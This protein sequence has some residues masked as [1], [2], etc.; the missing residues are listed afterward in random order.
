MHGVHIKAT[1]RVHLKSIRVLRV[2]AL[3]RTALTSALTTEI[4]CSLQ[5]AY[6]QLRAEKSAAEKQRAAAEF[7]LEEPVQVLPGVDQRARQTR[8]ETRSRGPQ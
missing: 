7:S 6:P 5:R 4:K 3:I 8:I 1:K 2:L